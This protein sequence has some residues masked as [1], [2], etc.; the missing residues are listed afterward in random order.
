[1]SALWGQVRD[2]ATHTCDEGVYGAPEARA[3]GRRRRCVVAA[4]PRLL[5]ALPCVLQAR[6]LPGFVQQRV[7]E[8]L[9]EVRVL[10]VAAQI[11]CF[12]DG[13]RSCDWDA[14]RKAAGRGMRSTQRARQP[15]AASRKRRSQRAVACGAGTGRPTHTFIVGVGVVSPLRSAVSIP[16]AA[17]AAATLLS[18]SW[19]CLGAE[20]LLLEWRTAA[21][22][23]WLRTRQAYGTIR[24]A[25]S[26]LV[27]AGHVP[28]RATA[29]PGRGVD[30]SCA[31]VL[32]HTAVHTQARERTLRKS[33]FE[34][35]V[36]AAP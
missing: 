3:H 18:G 8:A 22:L 5:G 35:G 32:S 2:P 29:R 16:E 14:E 1:M 33:A 24:H 26:L 9:D 6:S 19:L 11:S 20:R 23:V 21:A 13:Q 15:C 30:S 31:Q 7:V 25:A 4:G 17:V 34:S 28:A 10:Q 12:L 27:A 36:C